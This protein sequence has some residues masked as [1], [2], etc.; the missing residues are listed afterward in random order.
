MLSSLPEDALYHILKFVDENDDARCARISKSWTNLRRAWVVSRS[1]FPG[2]EGVGRAGQ[3]GV[4]AVA[5]SCDGKLLAIGADD[6]ALNLMVLD[7]VTGDLRRTFPRP[8]GTSCLD[9]S[10]TDSTVL[11]AGGSRDLIAYNTATGNSRELWRGSEELRCVTFSPAGSTIA[12]CRTLIVAVIDIGGP[13]PTRDPFAVP[14]RVLLTTHPGGP[15]RIE[16]IAF[17][18][19]GSVLAV[20]VG[21]RV[22]CYDVASGQVRSEIAHGGYGIWTIAYSSREIIAVGGPDGKLVLYD[23]SNGRLIREISPAGN[24]LCFSPDGLMIAFRKHGLTGAGRV[25]F[26]DAETGDLRFVISRN[27]GIHGLGAVR[28]SPDGKTVAVG[29]YKGRAAL[30][31]ATT[32]DLR[33]MRRAPPA[34]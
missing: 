22:K 20:G 11:V 5:F 2:G 15:R 21:T 25:F 6:F 13:D 17:S 24:G 32:G 9:F 10:P 19:T 29:D 1:S 18:P 28:F 26:Y 23:A 14:A 27:Y 30:Y 7:A 8:L 33:R 34:A 3:N 12:Y 16:G 31:D 4:Q